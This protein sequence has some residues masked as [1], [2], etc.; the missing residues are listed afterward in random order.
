M[1]PKRTTSADATL[2]KLDAL[3]PELRTLHADIHTWLAA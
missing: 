2:A 3:L 1:G